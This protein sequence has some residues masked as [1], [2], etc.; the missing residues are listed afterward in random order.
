MS[1]QFQLAAGGQMLLPPTLNPQVLT[2]PRG[3]MAS[4][5]LAGYSM[6]SAVGVCA[7]TR[8]PQR[9]TSLA[10]LAGFARPDP[11]L[12]LLVDVWRSLL[13]GDSVVVAKFLVAL[14]A[15]EKVVSSLSEPDLREAI[16]FGAD[17]L[18]V[19]VNDQVDLVSTVDVSDDL[20]RIAVPT[21]IIKATLDRL[22][23]P[24]QSDVLAA[25]IP[26]AG[27]V[28]LVGGHGVQA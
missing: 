20:P 6:G 1:G 14:G 8:H 13:A 15:G 9:V 24:E 16:S 23:T 5:A 22:A 2:I 7:A 26:G 19:G 27:M 17:N 12:S 25:A 18:P 21:L 11:Y 4:F 3:C 10:L 28:D